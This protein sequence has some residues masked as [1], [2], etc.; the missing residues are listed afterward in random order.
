[1][2]RNSFASETD[3][4]VLGGD[5]WI[6][7]DSIIIVGNDITEEFIILREL[8]FSIGDSVNKQI[9]FYDRERVFSLGIFNYVNIYPS[10]INEKIIIIIRIKE[11]WYIY[12]IPFITFRENSIN[13][14]LYGINF[15]YRNFRGR[16]ETIQSVISF[17]YDPIYSLS[18]LTP[19]FFDN[20]KLK[21]KINLALQKIINKSILAEELI[22]S[23]FEYDSY[24]GDI[25]FGWRFDLFNTV[26]STLGFNYIEAP[27]VEGKGITASN[28]KIDRLLYSSL[29]YVYDSR[30]LAQFSKNGIFAGIEFVHRGFGIHNID[31]NIFSIDFRE[32]RPVINKLTAKWRVNYRHTF[33][34]VVPLYDYS[35][36]GYKE[37]VRGHIDDDREGNNLI[38]SSLELS[39]PIIEEWNF[40]VK[41]PLLPEQLTSARIGVQVNVFGDT[42]ITYN[43]GEKLSINK[44]YSG[45]GAGITI[46]FLPYNAIRF[47][48]GFDEKMNG[49]FI[50]HTGFSF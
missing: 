4:L 47:E 10:I 19:A 25:T 12:P 48:Y 27:R 22:G 2:L 11:S 7:V 33:G 23:D 28:T 38:I 31:Y 3:S 20:R 1:M 30:D 29:N 36:L 44:F 43:N 42:G 24:F 40:S 39:Y 17:G 6:V 26:Y 49:E 16:D 21:F 32:Y 5:D 34:R 18:Y 46:L 13:K 14:A 8:T 45:W 50:F 41:L 9:L 15:L 35:F 37:A